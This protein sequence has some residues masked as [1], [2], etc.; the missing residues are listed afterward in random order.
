MTITAIIPT[1]AA[2]VDRLALLRRS[3]LSALHQ[4]AE[5][6]EIIVAGDTTDSPLD[7]VRELCQRLHREAPDGAAVRF[8]PHTPGHHDYGHSQIN[9][10]MTAA[11]G[12][13]LTFNDDDDVYA[14]GA[15][16][17][18]REYSGALARPQPLL[19]R[20]KSYHGPVFWVAPGLLGEGLIG[21]HCAVVPNLPSKLG[22]WSARYEGDWDFLDATLQKWGQVGIVPVWVNRLIAIA[23]PQ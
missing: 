15:F 13:W 1:A 6:D 10:A 8:V 2:D 21:G 16:A 3:V 19:F 7:G 11:R 12:D 18:I 9:H 4:L 14:A 22:Q 23:R 5:G 17:A 20:F